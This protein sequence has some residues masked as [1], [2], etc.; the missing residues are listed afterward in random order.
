[1]K[2]GLQL[3]FTCRMI[4]KDVR[5]ISQNYNTSTQGSFPARS[6]LPSFVNP[7]NEA[8]AVTTHMSFAYFFK[9]SV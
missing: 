6:Q 8:V 3:Q 9:V 5:R 4:D 2:L 7:V 1:M